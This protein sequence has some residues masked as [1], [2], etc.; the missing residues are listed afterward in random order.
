MVFHVAGA[1]MVLMLAGKLVEQLIGM[2]TQ[3]VDQHV[4]APAVCHAQY[5]LTGT[6]QAGV[7]DQLL[8]HRDQRIATLQR[9]AFGAG[10]LRAKIALQP[11]GGG[12]LAQEAALLLRVKGGL[13]HHRLQTLLQPAFLV[14][15]SQVHILGADG[16]TVSLLQRTVNIRQTHGFA[17]DSK[18]AHVKRLVEILCA[19]VMEGRVEIGHRFL[20]PQP[21]WIEVR[22]LMATKTEGIDQ[23]QHLHLLRIGLR[24]VKALAE[25]RRIFSQ[26]AEVV[27]CLRMKLIRRQSISRQLLKEDFPA[28]LHRVGVREIVLIQLLYIRLVRARQIGGIQ[29]GLHCAVLHRDPLSL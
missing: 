13:S 19:K 5:H 8:Q 4:Q 12:Q 18:G 25:T 21:E 6:V 28:V 14:G 29:P 22:L 23:L 17:A 1:Q 20:F 10:E 7:A 9:E 24:I 11:L 27:T 26:T 16:A 3:Y 2:F 15:V